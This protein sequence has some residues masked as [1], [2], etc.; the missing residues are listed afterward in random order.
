MGS[1]Y[2]GSENFGQDAPLVDLD[3]LPGWIIHEDD[4]LLVINKPGWLVCHPS[5]NGPYSS[6]V[7]AC[8][9]YTGLDR[10]HLVSRLDRETS[11]IVLLAKV[12]ALAKQLQGAIERSQPEKVYLSVLKGQMEGPRQVDALLGRDTQSL[13][14]VKVAVRTD[15]IGK[16]SQTDF[17]PLHVA[18]GYTLAEV[19]L[20]TGRKHQIRAHA[21]YIGHPVAGDKIYGPDEL[22]YLDFIDDGWTPRHEEL[23]EMQRQALHAWKLKIECAAGVFAFTAPV[24]QDIRDFCEKVFGDITVI[25]PERSAS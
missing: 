11:G 22:L 10:L 25:M 13:V 17:M 2:P 14:H 1:T 20:I 21:Q 8:R 3:E 24:P 19:R 12:P 6:L 7:G 23:L 15:G 9:E 4:E 18:N 16:P 5:K